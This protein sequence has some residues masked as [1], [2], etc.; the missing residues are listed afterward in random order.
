MLA[1]GGSYSAVYTRNISYF[2]SLLYGT[3]YQLN[4]EKIKLF[5]DFL[6]EGQRFFNRGYGAPHF[7]IARSAAYANGGEDFY[8]SLAILVNL[9]GIYRHKELMD[10]Y[11]SFNDYTYIKPVIKCFYVPG[12]L[13]NSCGD[14]YIGVRGC[15][16]GYS[17]TDVQN[18]EG[19]LNYNLSYGSNT[20]YMFY[21]DEYSSIGAVY[22]FSMFPGTTTYYLNDDELLLK[23]E[24]EYNQTWGHYDFYKSPYSNCHLLSNDELKAGVLIT[25]LHNSGISGKNTFIT[26]GSSIYVLGTG[27]CAKERDSRDI[28]TTVDQCM[29]DKIDFENRTIKKNESISNRK[30]TYTNLSDAEMICYK[31]IKEGSYKRTNL[32]SND[33]K[34]QGIIFCCYYNWGKSLDN[35]SY[36]YEVSSNNTNEYK[37]I[38]IVSITNSEEC[39]LIEFDNGTIIGYSYIPFNYFDRRGVRYSITPGF[40]FLK[41]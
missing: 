7:T 8:N 31:R 23:W 38:N 24:K 19:V 40:V 34:E 27:F 37:K 20:C 35:I 3:E 6:L 28:I 41:N 10:Y 26:F 16:D 18:Q 33:G 1:S 15:M 17:M 9:E 29:A 30:F 22:D 25:E 11:K 32:N 14:S 12:V 36:A 13:I 5:V 21:G 2:I 39:Q 4:E